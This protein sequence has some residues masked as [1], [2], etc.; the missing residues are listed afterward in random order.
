MNSL[1]VHAVNTENLSAKC[2]EVMALAVTL[3]LE[4]L[5]FTVSTQSQPLYI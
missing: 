2:D 4:I 3:T 1:N 5:N